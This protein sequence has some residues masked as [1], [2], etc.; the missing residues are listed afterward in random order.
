MS[1][2]IKAYLFS[3]G[4]K[5]T[6]FFITLVLIA[7]G[8][9]CYEFRMPLGEIFS[10]ETEISL[11]YSAKKGSDG[12]FYVLDDGHERL[13]C[14]DES[15]KEQYSI[16]NPSDDISGW[17]YMD[18]FAVTSDGVY[19]SAT[20]WNE[21]AI[22]REAVLLY[23]KN[24]NY[25]DTIV[26]RD[27]SEEWTNKHRFYGISEKNGKP[28]YVEC[29]S[30]SIK[31]GDFQIPYDNAF[32]A[33]SDAVFVNDTVYILDKNGTITAFGSNDKI[34]TVVYSLSVEND[35][36]I[37]PYRLAADVN[38]NLYFTDIR[39][40]QVRMV[41]TQ[42]K[43]SRVAYPDTSSLTVGITD[44]GELLLLDDEGLHIVGSD[45]SNVYLVLNKNAKNIMIQVLWLIAWIVA[46]IL[47]LCLIIRLFFNLHR[48]K[49]SVIQVISFWVFDTVAV[50]SVLLCSMLMNSFTTSYREKIEEQVKSA[51]YMVANQVSGSDIDNIEETGGFGGESY[52]RLCEIMENSFSMEIDF[53]K[54]VYC[55]I[56]KLSEDG[57]EGYAV[58][59]LDQSVG[60][61]F[62][63]DEVEQDEL[64][65]VYETGEAVWNQEV[66]DI[67]GTYLS[68][69]VPVYNETGKIC[70]AVA[71]GV[72][73]YVIT[74][75]LHAMITKILMSIVV[76]LLLVWL[77]SV[78]A[79]SFA[80]NI[81]VYKKNIA[82][83]EK[84]VLPG[85][86]VRLLVFLVFSAYNM[87]A[88]FLPVYLMRRTDIF[89]EQMRSLAGALPITVNIFIIG[90]MSL[91]CAKLV[92]RF[93]I[94][95]IMALSALCSL[96]GNLIIFLMP[97]FYSICIGLVLDGI[98]VG[99]ITNAVYVMLTY[100]KDE[101][102]RTWGLTIYNGA[103][104]SGINF[105]M[106]L[107]SMLAVTVGQNM[108]FGIV[109]VTWLIMII[110]TGYMVKQMDGMLGH[111]EQDIEE[112]YNINR[113]IS[114]VRFV[115]SK[116]V[117]SFIALIQ[118]PY[119]IFGS[120]VFYY[121]PIYCDE[122]GYSETICSVLIMLYSQIAVIG[123]NKLTE[124]VT[125]IFGS[126]AMYLAL[127]MN[128]AALAV[129]AVYPNMAG[130]I[131][132][133]L[134]LG[135]GASFG[136]PVQQNYYLNL[137]KV[138]KYGEDK[139]IGIYNFTEN[140]GESL[141]P[142]VFGRLMAAPRFGVSAGAFCGA[143]S[144]IGFLHFLICR[145]ELKDGNKEKG[146]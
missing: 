24:G 84:N 109:A 57:D 119:I 1:K 96:L 98:G 107:G 108:V 88:S 66:A 46:T 14:F 7:L 39:N 99:L 49:F 129:F 79:L 56:L 23:D 64:K 111:S 13:L 137:E 132:A 78:E 95:R 18:D 103:C 6:D 122:R 75:T 21:M 90:V 28:Q 68:V 52:N 77:I 127:G 136:K 142:V 102:N 41:N 144:G 34:G 45:E 38:G 2:K 114:G 67:S 131:I 83:G 47:V 11:G 145:K 141:G 101:V 8:I 50:V 5:W 32:N 97:N 73:T 110:L 72:E 30:D 124:R 92:Q 55:N 85:H 62:P 26:S 16:E 87:T 91:F 65:R 128:V 116:P 69:K 146:I 15:G 59:Y 60:S 17:L 63:L 81:D 89:P 48:K 74:D 3:K 10:V 76:L 36:N 118:N 9:F 82:T 115:L 139:S 123:T 54:Q 94:R 71:V 104:L 86:L 44:R 20:E 25:V 133:L 140:I 35:K 12:L 33:V 130:M 134:L 42:E 27:Y 61:Y 105:G 4:Y 106:M 37:V 112:E 143:V 31:I 22:A 19:I 29:L 58:A 100:V 138:K 93:G 126:Y 43:N 117:L 135:I 40:Q 113:S 51:A 125:K 80:N 120:F 53:Y 121:V 70:G